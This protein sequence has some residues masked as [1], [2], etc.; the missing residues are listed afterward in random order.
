[1]TEYGLF[2]E[3]DRTEGCFEA[4]MYT[5][6]EADA[7]RL[8]YIAE[9]EDPEDIVVAELCPE[10]E[11]QAKNGCEGCDT[12]HPEPTLEDYSTAARHIENLMPGRWRRS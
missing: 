1:M 10:H 3:L 8:E 6:E 11:G 12:E 9:G 5:R 2:N 7:R 4:G